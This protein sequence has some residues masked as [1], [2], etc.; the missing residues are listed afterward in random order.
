MA[1]LFLKFFLLAP[2]LLQLFAGPWCI[3]CS[4]LEHWRRY[5]L[6]VLYM[7]WPLTHSDSLS[8]DMP[9][10]NVDHLTDSDAEPDDK[11]GIIWVARISKRVAIELAVIV[12]SRGILCHFS[13]GPSCAFPG[14]MFNDCRGI[15]QLRFF[16]A[17]HGLN[18]YAGNHPGRPA[19]KWGLPW[20][21]FLI[22]S[23][24][25]LYLIFVCC[26][27]KSA[28]KKPAGRCGRQAL[29]GHTLARTGLASSSICHHAG[30]KTNVEE[31]REGRK[32]FHSLRQQR[33]TGHQT[34]WHVLQ[35]VT[36]WVY[37]LL[38][39]ATLSPVAASWMD[40]WNMESWSMK[41]K[42]LFPKLLLW[43]LSWPAAKL[44]CADIVSVMMFWHCQLVV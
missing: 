18:F 22:H 2:T 8:R 26:K 42:F 40:G 15:F 44:V 4:K 43:T 31:G 17:R 24:W 13:T 14:F 35:S 30:E 34:Q 10:P 27:D 38:F 5:G 29:V 32:D 21:S 11:A 16:I 3:V 23:S 19:A 28:K 20:L 33:E 25:M 41:W 12:N 7:V 9:F 37:D 36:H 6:S 1:H 39:E